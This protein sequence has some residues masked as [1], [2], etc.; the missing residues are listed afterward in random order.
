[1]S[2]DKTSLHRL[3]QAMAQHGDL[4]AEAYFS[5]SVAADAGRQR[6]L[7]QLK[8]LK[9]LSNRGGEGYRLSTRLSQFIDGALNSDRMRRLD[10]DLGSWVDL[11]EQQIALYHDAYAE[12]RLEDCDHF[13]SEVER[14]VFDLAETLED[15]TTYLL[16]LVNSR[17][18]SVRT[19]SEKKRQNAFYISRLEKLVGTI[20]LLQ[21]AHLLDIADPHESLQGLIDRHLIRT[22]PGHRQRLEGIL[23]TLKEFLFQLRQ[24]EARARLVRGFAFFL[25]Q[26]PDYAPQDWCEREQIP[27][28]WNR[29]SGMTLR[30]HADTL[31]RSLESELIAIAQKIRTD[32]EALL[33]KRKERSLNP[34]SVVRPLKRRVELPPYRQRLR[35]LF[36]HAR[37]SPDTAVSALAYRN[38]HRVEVDPP[39]WLS[40]VLSEGIRRKGLKQGFDFEFVRSERDDGFTGN[41]R[42]RDLNIV[43]RETAHGA[44]GNLP[45]REPAA[46]SRP[47]VPSAL[48]ESRREAPDEGETR[49]A[50]GPSGG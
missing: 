30:A 10:T 28:Q 36:D 27:A 26:N 16:M 41:L 40:C 11:L 21:P 8:Q 49:G 4:I 50:E 2:G 48:G 3:L 29:I 19:L 34:V 24:I 5:G 25:R 6:A 44:V 33:A 18:A 38:R 45:A 20:S 22:L 15:N 31:D 43:Y 35:Q 13:L 23:D 39:I 1:M 12:D 9:V 32:S 47:F 17:F 46:G 42:I 37:E 7:N 14:L